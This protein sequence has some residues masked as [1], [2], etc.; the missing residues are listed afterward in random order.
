MNRATS[1]WR[2]ALM[3][4]GILVGVSEAAVAQ[5]AAAVAPLVAARPGSLA[6]MPDLVIAFTPDTNYM[7]VFPSLWERRSVFR[8]VQA[9]WTIVELAFTRDSTRA[10]RV[11]G[12]AAGVYINGAPVGAG[13]I[14]QV[15][16]G[17]CG[18][19]PAWCP[20]RAVVEVVGSL[21]RTE[22]P[23]VAVS[24]PP[25]HSAETVD[26]TDDEFAAAS[27]ALLVVF[28]TAA[29]IRI[30]ITA[31]QMGTPTVYA[32]D[33]IDNERRLIV[34]AGSLDLGGGGSFSGLVVGVAADTVLRAASG[35]AKRLTAGR[36]EELRSVNAFDLNG[37]LRDE[38][39]LAWKSGDDWQF[40]LL[41]PD[42]LSRFSQLWRGPDLS[43]PAAAP[44]RPR[45]R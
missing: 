34:A 24:P 37:D 27:Q 39:L 43:L 45:R 7:L 15:L 44:A 30:R 29:G 19:P 17:F 38:L 1:Y 32:I 5:R 2:C 9:E 42:R 36:S 25:T 12:K 10:A 14:R 20:T 21:S 11:T 41:A 26:P 28:R 16:P 3:L 6:S 22:P 40:E 13:R 35:R 33:D 8:Q 31:E 18:D 4:F 23:I